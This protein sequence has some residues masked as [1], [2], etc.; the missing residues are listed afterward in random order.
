MSLSGGGFR[1]ALY[2]I[3]DTSLVAELVVEFDI[4]GAEARADVQDF[5][6]LCE[7]ADVIR[8]TSEVLDGELDR[9]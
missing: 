6:A 7:E 5:L 2:G 1:Q 3:G 4:D 9:S 8:A